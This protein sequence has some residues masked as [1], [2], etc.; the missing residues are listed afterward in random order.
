[1]VNIKFLIKRMN[2]MG[3]SNYSLAESEFASCLHWWKASILCNLLIGTVQGSILG[4]MFEIE[5]VFHLQ[6]IPSFLVATVNWIPL[7]RT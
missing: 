7:K 4:Q 2:I 5:F 6:M 3:L 1:L